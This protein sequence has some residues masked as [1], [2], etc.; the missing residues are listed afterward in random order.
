MVF[1]SEID[2]NIAHKELWHI[3]TKFKKRMKY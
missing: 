2:L 1:F 3:Q